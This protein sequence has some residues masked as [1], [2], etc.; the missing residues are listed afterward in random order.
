MTG[1]AP[2]RPA[3][4]APHA[5]PADLRLVLPALG[6]WAGAWCGL[7]GAARLVVAAVVLLLL[8]A[9]A[10]VL[11]PGPRAR[12]VGAVALAGA[13]GLGVGLARA[14][15]LRAGPVHALAAV[16]ASATADV[17]VTGDP[18]VLAA[19]PRPGRPDQGMVALPVRVEAVTARGTRWRVRL[20]AELLAR[21]S[22]WAALLPSQ[23]VV[24]H[25]RL[26]AAEPGSG[27]AAT[28][29]VAGA[30]DHVRPP[31]LLQRGAGS[32]RAGL[33]R[34]VAGLP[35]GPRGLLPGLVDGD[36]GLL[37]DA[38]RAEFRTAGLT[39]LVAV[40]G[41][42]VAFVVGAALLLG[43]WA[44]VRGRWLPAL[45][46]LALAG[47]VV[48]ARPQPSVLR[49]A[50]MGV[51]AL[52]G[53][54]AGRPTAPLPALA[55]AVLVL[56]VGDPWQARSYGFALSVLATAALLLLAPP[57]T[58]ALRRRGL[59]L[60]AAQALAVPVAAHLAT[61][62]VVVLLSGQ[63]SLVAVPAN[64][65]VAPLVAPATLLGVAAALVA[66]L[67][68]PVARVLA[69]LG[70][71]PAGLVV[72]VAAVASRLPGGA[73]PWPSGVPAALG[74][75]VLVA[76]GWW[77]GP[78]VLARPVVVPALAAVLALLALRLSAPH[79]PPEGW[80]VVACDVGQGDGL[81]LSTSEPGTAV[82]VDTGP[83]PAA[84]DR[85]LRTLGVHR[86]ALLVL[87]HDHADH[88]EGLPGALRGRSVG[89][90]LVSPLAEPPGEARRVAGWVAARGIE[91]VVAVPGTT[92]TW[93]GG[94][95]EVLAPASVTAGE[96]PNDAS[97][98]L[99]VRSAGLRILLTG[100]VTP[101]SQAAL[102]LGSPPLD[103][104]VDVLKVPHHGSV[105]Q[106]PGFLTGLR[107]RVALVSV[108]KSNDYGHPAPAT[109]DLLR[110]A[111]AV[112]GRTDDDGDLAV[113]AT[114]AGPA[115]VRRR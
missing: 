91:P 12:V 110:G 41:A 26:T 35:S 62:P 55:A 33:R 47:F 11:R 69:L 58:A 112:V 5:E 71:V 19:R 49:A 114:P 63:V 64:L 94:S 99:L 86:V 32:L 14:A 83:D 36:T 25:G 59:P 77:A 37:P 24:A 18:V 60:P 29:V 17:V 39:H 73:V 3:A 9:G 97:V 34:A 102:H 52:L 27:A 40:S 21:D 42:N 82:V 88:V 7:V 79:W 61:V 16:G 23:H 111:G 46:L 72:L 96:D 15:P 81:V 75:A 76:L 45:G 70:A 65:L 109:L 84:A 20:P 13:L 22:R 1:A 106:D 43:R 6:A 89:T 51:V 31:S 56:V 108:G 115:L 57:L 8:L 90:L 98:V 4:S 80:V 66:P 92:W 85:C 44:G 10:V 28:L 78:R 107:P 103:S 93:S 87:T 101:V 105:H 30:P 48:L 50:A 104:G 74:L 95:A 113:L 38:V 2:A 67:C 53:T 100:D 54:A 68:L